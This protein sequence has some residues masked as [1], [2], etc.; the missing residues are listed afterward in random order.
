M[1]SIVPAA[2]RSLDGHG[3]IASLANAGCGH[4]DGAQNSPSSSKSG[5][6]RISALAATFLVTLLIEREQGRCS[7]V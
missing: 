3:E 1:K 5:V 6:E 2:T 7:A 4:A